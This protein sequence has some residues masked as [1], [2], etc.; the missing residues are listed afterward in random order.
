M[1]NSLFPKFQQAFKQVAGK[2]SRPNASSPSPFTRFASSA[3][4]PASPSI[5]SSTNASRARPFIYVLGFMPIVCFG[6]GS[7]QISRLRWKLDM[8]DQFE[9]KLNKDTVRLPARIEQ[10]VP[11]YRTA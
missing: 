7:W 6:L 9:A 11:S 5:S 2:A 3:S 10:V 8:I 4:S 1:S